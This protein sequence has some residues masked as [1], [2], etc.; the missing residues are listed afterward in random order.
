MEECQKKLWIKVL[1]KLR[2]RNAKIQII[3]PEDKS[4]EMK[5]LGKE[6]KI[7]QKEKLEQMTVRITESDEFRYQEQS[8]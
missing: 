8:I 2:E 1:Q 7:L 4:K 5:D 6:L 3:M